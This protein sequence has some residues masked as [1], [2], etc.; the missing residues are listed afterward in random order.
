MLHA[1]APV[2]S[3]RSVR[4]RPLQLTATP[5]LQTQARSAMQ[6]LHQLA[7]QAGASATD[8]AIASSVQGPDG[9]LIGGCDHA[10]MSCMHMAY[11]VH[12]HVR[13][14]AAPNA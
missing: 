14:L 3:L 1:R 5:R 12:A 8:T 13:T 11:C 6:L 7:E 10:H 2:N 9:V 4:V